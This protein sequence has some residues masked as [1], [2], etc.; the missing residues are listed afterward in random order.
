MAANS[1]VP[2]LIP[3]EPDEFWSQIRLIIREEVERNRVTKATTENVLETPGLTEKP[4]FKI[5]EVCSLFKVTKPTIYDWIKHG[6]LKRVKI[7]SR[8]YFLGSDIR[9]LMQA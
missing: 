1:A 3:F 7:R 6:K 5:E 9:Q 2:I 8:V 4:L